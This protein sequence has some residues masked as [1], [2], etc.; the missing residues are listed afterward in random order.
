MKRIYLDN[1]A[2][3]QLLP[4]AFYAME[5]FLN[6]EFGNASSMHQEGRWARRALEAAREQMAQSLDSEPNQII[7][8]S[9][10]TEAN[11]LAVMG[12]A[13]MPLARVVTSSIEHPAVQGCFEVLGRRGFSVVRVPV[14]TT[15]I[16][17]HAEFLNALNADARMVSIMLVNNETGAIQPVAKL[18]A[19]ARQRGITFHTDAVQAVGRM[20]L[21]FRQLG[22]TALSLSAH[23]FHGPGG[24]GA[25]IVDNKTL[26]HP[27][28][29]GGHQE[30][31]FRPGTEPV[32]LVVGMAKALECCLENIEQEADRLRRLRDSLEQRIRDKAG[33]AILNGPVHDRAANVLNLRFPNVDAQV[34]VLALDLMG[35]ACSTGSACASGAS[36]PS[37][38]LLAM[39]L[40]EQEARSSIR[41]SL[42][43]FTTLDDV[44]TAAELVSKFIRRIATCSS[45]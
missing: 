22:V 9:G 1:N 15:G 6:R 26:L 19:E 42:C 27:V 16:V 34:A 17:D 31:G 38:T 18:A 23:K 24:I 43:R 3:T 45:G 29:F 33:V 37:P 20:N 5:P 7:F 44:E 21:S 13:G 11:H 36:T 14:D 41:F 4:E 25:L 39:G 10:G 8:T 28:A 40:S 2:T 12:F 35:L 32:A 30:F